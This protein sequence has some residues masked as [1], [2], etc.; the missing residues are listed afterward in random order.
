MLKKNR[1]LSTMAGLC[2]ATGALLAGS[3]AQALDICGT[4]TINGCP[5]ANVKV[6]AFLAANGAPVAATVSSGASANNFRVAHAS[7]PNSAVVL[8]VVAPTGC[9]VTLDA[10]AIQLGDQGGGKAIV[11][12]NIECFNPGTGTPGY[13]KNHPEAWP[14]TKLTVGGVVYTQQQILA[15]LGTPDGDKRYTLFRALVSAKLNCLIGNDVSCINSFIANADVWLCL[16]VPATGLPN[17]TAVGGTSAAWRTGEPLY[18]CLDAYN[19]G[20]LCAPHRR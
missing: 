14:V 19:N 4:V 18:L 8:V 20:Q 12:P 16:Y 5:A 10:A 6:A 7:V 15:I 1:F 17:G 13:W 9:C 11:C 2:V 3:S